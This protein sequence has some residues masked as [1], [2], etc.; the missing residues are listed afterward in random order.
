MIVLVIGVVLVAG[1]IAAFG[2]GS[3]GWL[4]F[5]DATFLHLVLVAVL[6]F[7]VALP[8]RLFSLSLMEPD[9]IFIE[10]AFYFAG[11]FAVVADRTG[12][13]VILFVFFLFLF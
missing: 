11:G 9:A 5:A 12:G 1:A 3:S 4:L 13:S 6:V 10:Q 7:V 8:E 2:L